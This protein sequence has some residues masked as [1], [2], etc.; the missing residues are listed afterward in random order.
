[1]ATKTKTLELLQSNYPYLAGEFGVA[2][3][4]IFGSVAKETSA[5]NSDVD[6]VVEFQKPIGFKFIDLA[7]YLENL[8]QAKVDLLTRDGIDNIRIKSIADDI[9]RNIIYVQAK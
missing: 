2:K 9:K 7:D 4:G 1:M 6:I 3:I 8:L 5:E